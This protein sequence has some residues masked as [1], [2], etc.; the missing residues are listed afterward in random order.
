[1][2]LRKYVQRTDIQVH[3]AQQTNLAKASGAV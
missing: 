3:V 2:A 1:M